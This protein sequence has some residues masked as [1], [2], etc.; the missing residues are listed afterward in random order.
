MSTFIIIQQMI[1]I[2]ILVGIGFFLCK[3]GTIDDAGRNRHS[4]SPLR[5]ALSAGIS[6]SQTDSDSLR[7]T[8]ILCAHDGIWN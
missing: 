6:N 1:V 4:L 2:A 3:S 8:E 5:T 7:R